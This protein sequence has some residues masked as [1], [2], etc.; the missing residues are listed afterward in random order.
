MIE[1]TPETTDPKTVVKLTSLKFF[2]RKS[3]DWGTTKIP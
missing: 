1:M 3:M 2:S